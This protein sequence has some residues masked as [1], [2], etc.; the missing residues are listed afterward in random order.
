ME[1]KRKLALAVSCFFILGLASSGAL[2]AQEKPEGY[3]KRPIECVVVGGPGGGSDIFTR[4]IC[5]PARRAIRNPLV[6]INKPGGAGAIASEYVQ[7]KPA[8]GYTLLSGALDTLVVNPLLGRVKYKYSDWQP[9]MRG[10]HDTMMLVAL[11]GGKFNSIHELIADAKARPGK[12][13]WGA[14][15]AATGFQSIAAGQFT[16]AVGIKVKLVSYDRTG[17]QH[18]A[19]LGGHV[20]VIMEE[21]GPI[22]ALLE[23]GKVKPLV[24]FAENRIEGFPEV[25]CTKELGAEAYMG[26]YRGIALK[27]GTPQPIVDYLHAVFKKALDS[28]FYKDYERANFLHLRPGY[29]GPKDF[30]KDFRAKIDIYTAEF[31]EK[32]I[33]IFKK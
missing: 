8:D 28:K 18:A 4:T 6:I 11:V 17:K 30:D 15:S 31:R 5:I 24:V 26:V 25:P 7:S 12:Q 16:E 23:A 20:P 21:P 3:P 32:N 22:T 14:G 10:Q 19:L 1:L 27:K 2:Y 13:F 9:L 29:L 33:G